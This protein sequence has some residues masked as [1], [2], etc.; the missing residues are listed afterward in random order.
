MHGLRGCKLLLCRC[1]AQ[2]PTACAHPRVL[3]PVHPECCCLCPSPSA[4][5]CHVPRM[6]LASELLKDAAD[7]LPWGIRIVGGVLAEQLQGPADITQQAPLA[8]VSNGWVNTGTGVAC[9]A[10]GGMPSQL[11]MSKQKAPWTPLSSFGFFPMA[12]LYFVPPFP[13]GTCA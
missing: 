9:A 6:G 1:L 10:P 13:S 11:S 3:L 4:A 12:H 5:A 7:A 2:W 8:H